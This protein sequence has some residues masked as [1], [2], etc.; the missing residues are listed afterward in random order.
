MRDVL[1]LETPE[2][3]NGLPQL[4]NDKNIMMLSDYRSM[5]VPVR[6]KIDSYRFHRLAF[7]VRLDRIPYCPVR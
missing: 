3:G 6:D 1:K 2:E 4:D 5:Y 7:D